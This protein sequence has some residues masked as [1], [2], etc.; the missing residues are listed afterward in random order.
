MENQD[1]RLVA[2]ERLLTIMD[3]LREKCPWDRKQTMETL[4]P[5]TIEELYELADAILKKDGDEIKK[6]LGDIMLHLV[7]YSKIASEQNLFDIT[8]VLNGICDKLVHRHPHIYGNIEVQNEEEVKQNWEK[9]KLKEGKSSVLEGVPVSL[10]AMVKAIRIQEKA[11]GVGF[12]WDSKAQVVEKVYEELEELKVELEKHDSNQIE[13]EFGD[14]LFSIINLSRF[15]AVNPE[16]ALEKTNL[17]FINRFQFLEKRAKENGK[18]L[19]DMTL[20]EMEAFWNEAKA[21]G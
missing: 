8:D 9:L 14:F 12:D 7:F 18:E 13:A 15:V 3:E 17:K 5:L 20:N 11:R 16:N 19:K 4:R 10:P 21:K 6:E 1:K 2:F